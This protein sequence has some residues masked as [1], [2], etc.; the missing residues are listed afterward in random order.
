MHYSEEYATS[1]GASQAILQAYN[2]RTEHEFASARFGFTLD[3]SEQRRRYLL[4]SLLMWPGLE[5]NA[6]QAYF[7]SAVMDDFPELASLLEPSLA[8]TN[9]H[10]FALTPT[11][12]AHA[13]AIGPWLYSQAVRE[14]S[15]G[16]DWR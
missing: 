3:A 9:E 15:A 12:M 2:Q 10:Y 7:G 14:Q 13:D 8:Q 5:L 16:Y 4:Q 11:G 6:Y 1:R